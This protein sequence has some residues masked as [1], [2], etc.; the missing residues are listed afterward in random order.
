MYPEPHGIVDRQLQD[1]AGLAAA[2]GRL[3]SAPVAAA[4]DTLADTFFNAIALGFAPLLVAWQ[5][6]YGR[7]HLPWQ[8]TR[9]PYQVW[10]SEIMLQQTQVSTVIAYY[11]RF[12]QHFPDVLALANAGQDAVLAL[13]SGLGYYSRARNLHRCAQMV[14]DVHGGVFPATQAALQTLPGIG[15]STAAAIAAFCFG[16]RVSI[17]DANVQRVLA[18]LLAYGSD[19]S[20]STHA[21]ELQQHARCLLPQTG[22]GW[23]IGANGTGGA[24]SVT[25]G[26]NGAGQRY[27]ITAYTQGLMDL[28]A[29]VCTPR[30]PA[31]GRCP[32][33]TLCRAHARGTP[34]AYP[35]KSSKLKR[36]AENWW[37]LAL[38]TPADKALQTGVWLEKRPQTGIWAGL[39][40]LPVFASEA[41]LFDG[42]GRWAGATVCQ[43]HNPFKHVLTHKDLY[44]HVVSAC[45]AAD[46]ALPVPALLDGRGNAGAWHSQWQQLGLPAP[47]RKW[48]DAAATRLFAPT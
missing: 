40:C 47:V 12:L 26:V 4:S 28:G 25:S 18:R 39:Y 7:H 9:D 30:N 38:H 45:L 14:R 29:T 6:Q 1:A 36:T 20:R 24:S 16:E 3:W 35:V 17:F 13:W 23:P 43:R 8:Q 37:L 5:K 21:R 34:L 42:L 27:A 11:Q 31:C 44:L 22:Q 46:G 2:S 19:L 48:L 32:V 41:A 10:L 33:R 15:P